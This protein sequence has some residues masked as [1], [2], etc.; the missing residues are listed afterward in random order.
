MG[1]PPVAPMVRESLV[2]SMSVVMQ[3]KHCR[4]GWRASIPCRFPIPGLPR[5]AYDAG[6]RGDRVWGNP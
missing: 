2:P 3:Q 1:D 4:R 6:R 5:L